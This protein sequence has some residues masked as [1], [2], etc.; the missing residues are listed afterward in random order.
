MTPAAVVRTLRASLA[1]TLASPFVRQARLSGIPNRAVVVRHALP[2]ALPPAIATAALYVGSL[3]GGIVVV[4][5]LFNYPGLGSLAVE[6]V[7]HRD[8][9]V[10]QALAMVG[11][12]AWVVTNAVAET[13]IH[14]V[15]PR[16]R[17]GAGR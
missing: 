8:L 12:V 15:D 6:A 16:T 9:P 5:T 11:A 13:V 14:R 17:T 3:L 10:V 2:A 4:E 7:Q 1:E